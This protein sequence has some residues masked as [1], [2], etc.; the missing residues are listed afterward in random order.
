MAQVEHMV[1]TDEIPVIADMAID[2]EDRIWIVRTGPG[3]DG[4]GPTD[5][6]TAE[7]E[8]LG[9]LPPGAVEIPSAFGPGGLMAY[10]E[11]GELDVPTVRVVR[12]VSLER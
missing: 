10:V 2:R 7:G 9:S 5:L 1:F 6:M 12:L 4:E 8:Y 11:T 3:G